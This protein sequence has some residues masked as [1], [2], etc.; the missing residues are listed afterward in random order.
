MPADPMTAPPTAPWMLD[1]AGGVLACHVAGSAEAAPLLLVHSVN[2]A[3]GV[4]EVAPLIAHYARS[5]RVYALELPGFGDSTRADIDYTPPLMTSAVA[6]ATRAISACHA[7]QPI[8]ALALSLA[9]EFLARA[10]RDTPER[11]RS[12]ALVSPTGFAGTKATAG[13]PGSTRALP[14]LHALLARRPWSRALFDL[15]TRRGSV[16]YFLRRTFGR[17]EID[18]SLV[19]AAWRAARH[20]EAHH[21]P[22]CFLCGYLFSRDMAAVYQAL[23]MPVWMAHGVRGDFTDYRLKSRLGLGPRWH[24]AV[25]QTGALP[26][27]EDLPTFVEAYSRFLAG[28]T[29]P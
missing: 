23:S 15:L 12:L 22:L 25:L 27:F 4:H 3:A 11:Y 13:P 18:E 9:C 19:D 5:R 8:D 1:H 14:R 28:A 29:P 7:G 24:F 16:R 20:P 17:Q 21:A 6:T 10:A 26:W 2:A